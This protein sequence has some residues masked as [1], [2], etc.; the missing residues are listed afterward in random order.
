MPIDWIYRDAVLV[1]TS[2]TS[3]LM[4]CATWPDDV[5]GTQSPP[6]KTP[7][8]HHFVRAGLCRAQIPHNDPFQP[9]SYQL[10]DTR[11][12]T[13][14]D[15]MGCQLIGFTETLCLLEFPQLHS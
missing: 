3:L 15:L 13:A 6:S 10:E 9:S 14:Q 5:Q 11:L 12:Y 7:M 8:I 1:G 2:T 4:T